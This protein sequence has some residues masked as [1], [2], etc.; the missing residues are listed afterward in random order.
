MKK[1]MWLIYYSHAAPAI[2]ILS[3]EASSSSLY[4]AFTVNCTSTG[5]VATTVNWFKS[6]QLLSPGILYE[7][8]QI[9]RD[10]VTSTYDNLLLVHT[11]TINELT[12]EYRCELSNNVTRSPAMRD[13]MFRGK[14]NVI[15]KYFFFQYVFSLLRPQA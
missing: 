10:G 6:G 7:M 4:P 3:L 11:L 2:G 9:L 1:Y 5:S 14:K 13:T 15:C 12:G 8:V